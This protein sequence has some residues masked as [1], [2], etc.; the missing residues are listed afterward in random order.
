MLFIWHYNNFKISCCH[1]TEL[2]STNS[3]PKSDINKTCAVDIQP[4]IMSLIRGDMVI[5][6]R[7]HESAAAAAAIVAVDDDDDEW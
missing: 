3:K 7:H 4:C 5:I 2:L 6:M 1:L